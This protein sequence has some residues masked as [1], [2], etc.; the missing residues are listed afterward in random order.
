MKFGEYLRKQQ[1]A[2]W[3]PHYL[4]YAHLKYLIKELEPIEKRTT[5]QVDEG[6]RNTSL[7][8]PRPTDSSGMPVNS[9]VTAE[10]FYSFI[11][12]EM[13]KIDTFTQQKVAEI[14]N[15]LAEAEEELVTLEDELGT[16]SA[17]TNTHIKGKVDIVAKTFLRLEKYVNLNFTGFHKI[18]KKHDKRLPSLACKSFYISR[19]HQQSWIQIDHSDII[20]TMSRVYTTIRGDEAAV[21]EDSAKQVRKTCSLTDSG[22]KRQGARNTCIDE[23]I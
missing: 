3:A 7:T 1:D 13:R 16:G 23:G 10:M 8:V 20:V 22:A 15:S 19:L 5:N 18:L 11:E 6:A 2:E 21:Q 17:V 4:N 12:D 9:D 14:R